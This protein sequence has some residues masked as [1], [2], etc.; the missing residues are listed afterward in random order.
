M[1]DISSLQDATDSWRRQSFPPEHITA[2]METMG[3]CEEAG[4]LAHAVLKMEQGIRGTAD[5]HLM[6]AADALGDIVIYACGVAS[7]LGLD[8]EN[9]IQQAWV[10]VSKRD[11]SKHKETG[12]AGLTM[13][14]TMKD[15]EPELHGSNPEAFG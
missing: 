7:A 9:C 11:W 4:E 2:M 10:Q 3:V 12:T 1:G 13:T 6:E 8:F 15:G 14:T 5:K